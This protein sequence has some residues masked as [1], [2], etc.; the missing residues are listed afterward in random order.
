MEIQTYNLT[1]T[2]N[3]IMDPNS[4]YDSDS[5]KSQFAKSIPRANPTDYKL[6]ECQNCN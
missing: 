3:D 6:L 1:Y 4:I 2:W 5:K